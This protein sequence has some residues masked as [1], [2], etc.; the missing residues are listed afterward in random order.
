MSSNYPKA[1]ALLKELNE[2]IVNDP[3]LSR[4]FIFGDYN[5]LQAYQESILA[6]LLSQLSDVKNSPDKLA[7]IDPESRLFVRTRQLAAVVYSIFS[8]LVILIDQRTLLVYSADKDTNKEFTCD[9]RT[10]NLF[11]NLIKRDIKFFQ[12]LHTLFKKNLATR[13]IKRGQAV[14]YL[15]VI[16]I[17]FRI[18]ERLNFNQTRFDDINFDQL[19]EQ[20]DVF[21]ELILK[22]AKQVARSKF[23]IMFLR[24]ILNLT[25]IQILLAPYDPRNSSELIAACN[26]LGIKTYIF[27]S[28]NL[29]KYNMSLVDAFNLKGNLIKSNQ[30][31]V[32]SE[33]WKKELLRLGTYYKENEILV[34]GDIK[35]DYRATSLVR[36]SKGSRDDVTTV[37][38]PYEIAAPKEEVAAYMR[39]LL[40]FPRTRVA[41]KMRADRDASSQIEEY[42]LQDVRD[43]LACETDFK[44]EDFDVV[45]GT[46]ST[47]LYE[48]IGK[49]KPVALLKTSLDYGEGMVINNLAE[50]IDIQDDNLPGKIL[51]IAC[52][53]DESLEQ[54]R[55]RLYQGATSLEETLNSI[56]K[57]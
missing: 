51:D 53:S 54:R 4:L 19:G 8:Y 2:V 43:Q 42:G 50:E 32:L 27:Q 23:R 25:N 48:M 38:F 6:D 21:K 20:R 13:T 14:G 35:E 49:L 31:I 41:F 1:L 52:A 24:N 12:I 30:I 7:H 18:V 17:L 47:L 3:K 9:F 37:L 46:Y 28:G 33:Y 16:D 39:K 44:P 57:H 45:A 15:E 22:Y 34:G 5:F 29:S 40:T 26:S 56:L 36:A 55:H 10:V 11:K